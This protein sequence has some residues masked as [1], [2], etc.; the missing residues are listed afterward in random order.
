[1]YG[2]LAMLYASYVLDGKRTIESVPEAVRPTVQE[3]LDESI[4]KKYAEE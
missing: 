3:I 2:A 4:G 1:M